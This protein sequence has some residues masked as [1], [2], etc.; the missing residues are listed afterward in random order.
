MIFFETDG[1]SLILGLTLP[2]RHLTLVEFILIK[3][4]PLG[5]TQKKLSQTKLLKL[6]FCPKSKSKQLKVLKVPIFDK[7]G[8][9]HTT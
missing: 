1:N 4:N 9:N 2:Q 6:S 5:I 3:R 8:Y 7:I